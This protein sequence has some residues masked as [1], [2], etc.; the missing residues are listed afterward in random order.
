MRRNA[1]VDTAIDLSLSNDEHFAP[2]VI[3]SPVFSKSSVPRILRPSL[4]S[5]VELENQENVDAFRNMLAQAPRAH[6]HVDVHP[7][8]ASVVN[9]VQL[10]IAK[11]FPKTLNLLATAWIWD[12]TWLLIRTK[13]VWVNGGAQIEKQRNFTTRNLCFN[14]RKSEILIVEQSVYI[15]RWAVGG[16]NCLSKVLW[17]G[18]NA[19][20]CI[21][22]TRTRLKR[23]KTAFL[24]TFAR[25][26]AG[27]ADNFD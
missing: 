20:S 3:A 25:S 8:H 16:S 24:Q 7:H 21:N 14:L 5:P 9:C 17:C 23:D 19:G 11:C 18:S 12:D 26:L 6:W 1:W 10:C 22:Q 2:A 15:D 13:Q 4:F 27:V